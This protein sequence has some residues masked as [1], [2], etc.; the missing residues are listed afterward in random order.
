VKIGTNHKI[1]SSENANNIQFHVDFFSVPMK[2]H[3]QN[4]FFGLGKFCISMHFA[5]HGREDVTA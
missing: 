1:V 2:V 4:M 5:R 3:E